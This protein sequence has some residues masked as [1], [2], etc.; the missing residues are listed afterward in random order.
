M[1]R[2]NT[3]LNYLRLHHYHMTSFLFD[4]KGI[5]YIVLFE[6]LNNLSLVNNGFCVLLTFIDT[7]TE[8]R[9]L[10]VKANSYHFEFNVR[11]FRDFF[12]IA[13]AE[14]LGD[15]FQQFYARFNNF[16]PETISEH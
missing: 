3:L 11:E 12:G 2:I 1:N 10:S 7:E 16:I 13:Y 6:D 9:K 15:V 4:Y 5:H 14:N 8:E